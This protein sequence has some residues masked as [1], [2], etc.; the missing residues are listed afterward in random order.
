VAIEPLSGAQCTLRT[1]DYVAEIA[2]IGATLRALRY[3]GRDLIV[4]FDA[5]EIRPGMRGAILAPWPN[6]TADGRYRFAD[7]EHQLP[8]NEI[9]TNNASHGLVA[10]M[11]FEPVELASGSARLCGWI[12]PQPGYPWRVRLDVEYVLGH[13]GL[14][15]AVVATNESSTSAPFG[16]GIHPYL[17]GGAPGRAA[18]DDWLLEAPVAEVILPDERMLPSAL[19]PVAE[20][21][22]LDF[23]S[24]RRVGS[25]VLNHAF[26]SIARDEDGAARVRVVGDGGL[27]AEISWDEGCPWLQ[28]YTSDESS[29]DEWR[30]AIAVEPQSCAPD[31]LNSGR[32]LLALAPG[33]SS[34]FSWR[35][36]ALG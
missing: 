31:A 20:H 16:V 15:I 6:R 3:R 26:T 33:A 1:G 36:R 22:A 27:G 8:I 9:E 17:L 25:D 29:G 35:L 13:D 7:A 11:R 34:R 10:W 30:H 2:S 32:G 14:S 18:V 23:R 4:S 19:V 12:E 21:G 28:L 5:D 24:A